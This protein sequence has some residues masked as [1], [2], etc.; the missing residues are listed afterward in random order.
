MEMTLL[1]K[2]DGL[3]ASPLDLLPLVGAT[4][5]PASKSGDNWSGDNWRDH[6]CWARLPVDRNSSSGIEAEV[7]NCAVCVWR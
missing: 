5:L 4:V 3:P 7:E 6:W 2:P 1:S